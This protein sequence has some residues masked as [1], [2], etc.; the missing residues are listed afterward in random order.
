MLRKIESESLSNQ[1]ANTLRIKFTDKFVTFTIDIVIGN[2]GYDTLIAVTTN[3]LRTFLNNRFGYSAEYNNDVVECTALG[4]LPS[5][6]GVIEL[7]SLGLYD[8]DISGVFRTT[9]LYF[10]TRI[11]ELIHISAGIIVESLKLMEELV[12][13]KRLIVV[14][15]I[16]RNVI[17]P[18]ML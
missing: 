15:V 13:G 12:V 11:F 18:C 6:F 2:L 17:D 14:I 7:I 16:N 4:I 5:I 8:C 10:S 3:Q 1:I 9:C